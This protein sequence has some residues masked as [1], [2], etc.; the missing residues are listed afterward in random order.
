MFTI[1]RFVPPPIEGAFTIQG[2]QKLGQGNALGY[3]DSVAA[4]TE[5]LRLAKTYPG[6][7]FEVFELV[8]VGGAQTPDATW[9]PATTTQQGATT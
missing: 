1:L 4:Q 8:L 5:A 9:T 2:P 3:E 7:R 6:T